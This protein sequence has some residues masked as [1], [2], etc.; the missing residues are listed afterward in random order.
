MKDVRKKAVLDGYFSL[1]EIQLLSL[2]LETGLKDENVEEISKKLLQKYGSLENIIIEKEGK[3]EMKGIGFVKRNRFLLFLEIFRRFSLLSI[4]YIQDDKECFLLTK[5]FFYKR[6]RECLLIFV[7]DD[8]KKVVKI[9]R[10]DS[11][12]SNRISLD[13]EQLNQ[14]LKYEHY[15]LIFVHNHP[16]GCILPSVEDYNS[17]E[18]ISKICSLHSIKI[19]DFMIVSDKNWYSMLNKIKK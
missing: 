10:I 4:D 7:L 6:K 11:K 9:F 15:G 2:I 19:I 1:D 8:T 18:R 13:L 5:S 16:S 12:G 14:V 3:V 17:F